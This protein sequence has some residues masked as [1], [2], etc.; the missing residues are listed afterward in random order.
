MAVRN[1]LRPQQLSY[2]SALGDARQAGKKEDAQQDLKRL[3][4][5][6]RSTSDFVHRHPSR[7]RSPPVPSLRINGTHT[8]IWGAGR[9]S[10]AS[11][12]PSLPLLR[13]DP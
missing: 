6:L 13:L 10:G 11:G 7:L 12:F 4:K 8:R 2:G 1:S 3:L 9:R 5:P